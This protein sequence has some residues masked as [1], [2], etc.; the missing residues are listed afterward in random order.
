MRCWSDALA[1]DWAALLLPVCAPHKNGVSLCTA[2]RG[3]HA[4]DAHWAGTR[5]RAD[6]ERGA[7]SRTSSS[8][9]GQSRSPKSVSFALGKDCAAQESVDDHFARRSRARGT[10]CVSSKTSAA[11]RRAPSGPDA[12]SRPAGRGPRRS[13]GPVDPA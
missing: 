9:S 7:V 8:R 13:R 3:Q 10:Q 5:A 1:S 12:N 6:R 2:E 11:P 4:D